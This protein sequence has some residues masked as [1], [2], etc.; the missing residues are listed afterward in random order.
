MCDSVVECV[1]FVVFKNCFVLHVVNPLGGLAHSFQDLFLNW[2]GVTRITFS[3]GL[4]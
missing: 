1:D 3:L 4:L 2:L